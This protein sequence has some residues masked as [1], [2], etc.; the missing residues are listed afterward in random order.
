MDE[1]PRLHPYRHW[2]AVAVLVVL[3]GA[4]LLLT[5]RHSPEFSPTDLPEATAPF[6][7]LPR[8]EDVVFEWL[9]PRDESPVS[10][11][12]LDQ[13]RA[14]RWR[15]APSAIGRLEVPA[16]QVQSLPQDVAYWRPVAVP[17]GEP[18]RPG[19]LAAIRFV[20]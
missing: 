11:E 7:A 12:L 10:V 4:V 20:D 2:I 19:D 13:A 18:A 16:G 3:T 6:G 14:V 17:E 5:R 8:G 1:R 9:V 15:S